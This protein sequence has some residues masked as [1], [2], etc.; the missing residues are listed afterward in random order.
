[1]QYHK[2]INIRYKT[3]KIKGIR[4][5]NKSYHSQNMFSKI[6]RTEIHAESK[7]SLPVKKLVSLINS[8]KSK[9]YQQKVN[10]GNV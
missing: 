8:L 3:I 2:G 6:N 1:M 10:K 5:I 7:T 4:K 9:N